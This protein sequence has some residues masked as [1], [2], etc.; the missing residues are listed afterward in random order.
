MEVG[1]DERSNSTHLERRV[2]SQ[3]LVNG[4]ERQL[5]AAAHLLH[6]CTCS[7]RGLRANYPRVRVK[8]GV[9]QSEWRRGVAEEGGG[10]VLA[11]VSGIASC[12]RV[13]Y[14]VPHCNSEAQK[15]P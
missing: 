4:G 2:V 14:G 3:P 11:G 8:E 12:V 6:R 15:V 9:R 5:A 13:V 7:R 10:R 1:A